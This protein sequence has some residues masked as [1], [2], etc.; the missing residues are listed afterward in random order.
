MAIW[1]HRISHHAEVAYP[2]LANGLLSI[3]FSD[4]NEP[5]FIKVICGEN[6]WE[7]FEKYFDDYWGKRPKTRYNLWRFIVEMRKGDLIVVPSWG[8]FSVYELIEDMAR[9]V[10]EIELSE[11][12]DWHGN[13]IEKKE[14]GYLHRTTTDKSTNKSK[15]EIIDLGFVR[16]VKLIK[17]DIPRNEYADS[18]LTSRMKIRYT[19]ADISDL[20]ES[21]D[22]ALDA[23]KKGQPLNIHSQII[24]KTRQ[25]ILDTIRTELNP[26]KFEILVKWYFQRIGA[27]DVYIPSK[28]ESEKEGDADVVAVFEPLKIIIYAQVKFHEDETD[29]WAI[30]Q[31]NDYKNQKETMDDGY[32]KI[33]WVV[34]SA[35]NFSEKCYNLAKEVKVQ[36]VDGKQFTKMLLEAGIANL[37]NAL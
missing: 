5:N 34:S 37:D 21:I 32:T 12:K 8:T 2:L 7:S 14:D 1:L 10:S 35:D 29:S 20:K 26:E 16:K 22:K 31:I 19:N 33:G 36:L 15:D 30:E 3:G 13:K 17:K 9:P 11:I 27:S 4:F 24:D 25:S 28:N 23:F 6:G 18:A